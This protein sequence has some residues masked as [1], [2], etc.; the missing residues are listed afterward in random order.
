[1]ERIVFFSKKAAVTYL[2][3]AA[4]EVKVNVEVL[5]LI[6]TLKY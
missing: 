3:R 1:M 6:L 4:K 2:M 5:Y